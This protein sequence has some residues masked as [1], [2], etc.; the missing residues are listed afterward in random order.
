M[1]EAERGRTRRRLGLA[2]LALALVGAGLAA[3]AAVGLVAARDD[4]Q[5]GRA[6]AELGVAAVRDADVEAAEAAFV[7]ARSAF[8]SAG[9]RLRNP[10]L[11]AAR[12]LPVA[13]E[14]LRTAV[15]LADAGALVAEAG[16]TATGAVVAL[17]GGVQALAPADGALPVAALAAL[18]P[19]L[20]EARGLLADASATVAATPAQGLL[21]QVADARRQLTVQLDD[22]RRALAAAEPLVAALPAFLGADGPRR[23]FFAAAQ[24]AELRGSTGFIGAFSILTLD[25]GRFSFREFAAIQDLPVAPPDTVEPP[26]PDFLDRYGAFGGTGYWQNL[27]LSPDFPSTG[28]ALERLWEA[29]YGEP[30][31]G[32]ISADPFALAALLELAG[33]TDVPGVGTVDADTVVPFVTNEAYAVLTDPEERKRLLG[34]VA[35]AALAGFINSGLGGDGLGGGGELDDSSAL[36]A[37]QSLGGAAGR[38]HVLVHATDPEV[39]AAFEGAGLA[40]ALLNPSG[41]YFSAFLTGASGSKVDYYLDRDLDYAVTLEPDGLARASAT[42]RLVNTAPSSGQ[43]PY[44]IGPNTPRVVAGEN[45]LYVGAYLASDAELAGFAA[46]GAAG[47][48]ELQTEL[49][50]P[51]VE[52]YEELAP[53]AARTL[54]YEVVRPGG[55]TA[56]GEGGRYQLTVQS[57]AAIRLAR[58]RLEIRIPPGMQVTMA[59][60]RLQV[61][62]GVVRYDGEIEGTFSAGV[63]FAPVR[64][65][66]TAWQRLRSRL[67]AP[68]VTFG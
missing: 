36:H 38:G 29:T 63:A 43:P 31:D 55:W 50:H 49:G 60:E 6:A 14:N 42:L 24:P 46:D 1:G 51:V 48:G 17:P 61:D 30:L 45:E 44:V 10:L 26:N 64:E 59:D 18:G 8:R 58:L 22:A 4:L 57:Q 47:E 5:A 28:R 25:R 20:S 67:R 62:A 54:A 7:E 34:D 23:Y 35:A 53:G 41:D 13:G 37:L 40:G 52:T 32:T 68:L 9:R 16:R 12:V 11:R 27:N 19:P 66:R 21:G 39:Q 2:A 56:A 3:A 65:E 33:P 15:G